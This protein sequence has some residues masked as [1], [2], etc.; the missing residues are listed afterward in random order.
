M[1]SKAHLRPQLGLKTCLA[2]AIYY[3]EAGIPV[4]PRTAFDWKI[5]ENTP[6]GAAK[7]TYLL[8][9]KAPNPGQI[10]RAQMQAEVLRL[11]AEHGLDAFYEG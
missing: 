2:P 6:Q 11:I 7:D 9:G 5:A 10:F 3:A 1:L 4:G 8:D